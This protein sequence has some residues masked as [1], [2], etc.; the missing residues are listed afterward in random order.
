MQAA[1]SAGAKLVLVGEQEQMD[2]I[3]HGGALRYLSQRQSCARLNT[4]RRQRHPWARQAVNQLR[5]GQATA[6]LNT[7]SDKGLLHIEQTSQHAREQLVKHWQAYTEANPDKDTMILAQRWKDVKPL[8]DLVRKVY[9]DQGKLG[10]ENITT[11]CT[12]SNQSLYFAFSKGERVRLTKNDYRRDFTNGDTGTLV[13]VT[14][15]KEDIRFTVK[16]DSGRTV[17]FNQS[18]YADDKGRLHLVQ[19]YASTVYSSQGATVDGDTFV[20][21]NTAMDRAASYVAGSRHKDN[22]HWFVN[23]QELDAQSGQADKGQTPDMATRLKTLARCMSVNKHKTMACEYLAE[24]EAVK[25]T[26]L[27]SINELAA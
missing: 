1:Q 2:A 24:Q 14:Q 8:N 22:C 5:G 25:Q 27:T 12:V 26:E 3:S 13:S 20:L 4:I 16:L 7:F 18:D 9:Q 15:L 6:A 11:E 10:H 23:G 17:T 19:S 21:Y